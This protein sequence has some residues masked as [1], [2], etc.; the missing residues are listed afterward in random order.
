[1]TRHRLR[2]FHEMFEAVERGH[3]TAEMRWNDRD[4]QI[5][6]EIVLLEQDSNLKF[7]GREIPCIITHVLDGEQWGIKKGF[8]MLSFRR[9]LPIILLTVVTVYHPSLDGNPQACPGAGRYD[10]G[11]VSCASNVWSCGDVL[12]VRYGGR[13]I[14][15]TVTDRVGG[16]GSR[17]L[18]L[19]GGAWH[20]LTGGAEPGRIAA[21]V[22]RTH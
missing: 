8:A 13:E 10:H 20:R 5:A 2:T 16:R 6:D 11:A 21:K 7:T 19:S 4:F 15:C 1:M 22:T 3:K 17:V 12:R 9:L 18:D 14:T